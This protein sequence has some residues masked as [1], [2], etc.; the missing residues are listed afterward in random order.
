MNDEACWKWTP[1]APAPT[2]ALGRDTITAGRLPTASSATVIR[3][4]RPPTTSEGRA[5]GS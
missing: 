5:H 4:A 1:R 2:T 3:A